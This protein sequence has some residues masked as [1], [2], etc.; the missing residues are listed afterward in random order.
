MVGGDVVVTYGFNVPCR[1]FLL[2]AHVTRDRRMPIA[3]EF[4]LRL[5]K[6]TDKL[7]ASRLGAFFG[8]TPIETATVL[9]DLQRKKHVVL[10]GDKVQLTAAAH[11]KFRTGQDGMPH[12]LELETWVD[13]VWFD[14]ISRNITPNDRTRQVEHLINLMPSPDAKVLPTTFA[15]AAFEQNFVEY[16]RRVRGYNN[17]DAVSLYAVS[18]VTADRY[19]TVVAYGAMDL[20][21]APEPRLNSRLLKVEVEDRARYR[22]LSDAMHDAV[23]RLTHPEPSQAGYADFRRLTADTTV[24]EH[25]QSAPHFSLAGWLSDPRTSATPHRTAIFGASYIERNLEAMQRAIKRNVVSRLQT[26]KPARLELY[27]MR[28]VGTAWGASPDLPDFLKNLSGFV[29][30]KLG[31]QLDVYSSLVAPPSARDE[32]RKRFRRLF[33]R[34]LVAPAGY[35]TTGTEVVYLI[36]VAALV[37]TQVRV[38]KAIEVPVGFVLTGEADLRRLEQALKLDALG[39]EADT[40]WAPTSQ[41]SPDEPT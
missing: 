34:G 15:R 8:F 10:A 16:L 13:R 2:T 17:P 35:L 20:Q 21:L 28:P 27:W 14:L 3:D 4:I 23:R 41:E 1:R 40:L 9:Q 30:H 37:L 7:E 25:V 11:E 33:D 26:A 18:D 29:R 5:L 22:A 38:E 19:G 6:L 36:G 12:I 24:S 31:T 32:T 39:R